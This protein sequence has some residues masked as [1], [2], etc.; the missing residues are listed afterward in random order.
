MTQQS[1]TLFVLLATEEV[2]PA[3]FDVSYEIMKLSSLRTKAKLWR[4]RNQESLVIPINRN[5]NFLNDFY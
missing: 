3:N 4:F 5:S 1:F 2:K